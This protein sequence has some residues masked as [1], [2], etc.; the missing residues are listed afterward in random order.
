VYDF[1]FAIIE[2]FASSYCWY[3]TGDFWRG[4]VTSIANFRWKG[5]CPTNH[6]W[7]AED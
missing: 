2:L 7:M 1:L 3:V 4:W 5:T 6:C